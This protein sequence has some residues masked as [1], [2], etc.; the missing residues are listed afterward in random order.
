MYVTVSLRIDPRTHVLTIPI[1]SV[2]DL[3]HPTVYVVN[4]RHEIEERAVELGLETSVRFEVLKGL[5]EGERV[6]VGNRELVQIG[7]KVAFR[8][9]ELADAK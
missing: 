6:M 1:E 9:I 8:E 2:T 3:K 4:D 5:K 7:Q